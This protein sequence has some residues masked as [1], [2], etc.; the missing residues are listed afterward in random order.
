MAFVDSMKEFDWNLALL[1]FEF[2]AE[3]VWTERLE[4]Y[5]FTKYFQQYIFFYLNYIKLIFLFLLSLN[6]QDT[7]LYI[8]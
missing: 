7:F 8:S 6:L 4:L 5:S 2:L 1:F 3:F